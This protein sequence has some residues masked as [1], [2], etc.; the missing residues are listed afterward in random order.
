ML[1]AQISNPLLGLVICYALTVQLQILHLFKTGFCI[2]A[3]PTEGDSFTA[4]ESIGEYCSSVWTNAIELFS[5]LPRGRSCETRVTQADRLKLTLPIFTIEM[6]L[7]DQT[8][9][10]D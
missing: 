7:I 10:T 3:A 4:V 9:I 2:Q 1:P 5:R 6:G 8:V